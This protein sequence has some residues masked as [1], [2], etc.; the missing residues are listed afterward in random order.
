MSKP[1]EFHLS[2]G[3][4]VSRHVSVTHNKQA[5]LNSLVL[6]MLQHNSS[7]LFLSE[8]MLSRTNDGQMMAEAICKDVYVAVDSFPGSAEHTTVIREVH[9]AQNVLST[10]VK[11]Q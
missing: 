6:R 4:F 9:I 1:S 2:F 11:K 5:S 7:V 3:T 10:N 8:R